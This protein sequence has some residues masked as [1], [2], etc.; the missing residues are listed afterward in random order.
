[1]FNGTFEKSCLIREIDDTFIPF[2]VFETIL[3]NPR[4]FMEFESI[5]SSRKNNMNI[6]IDSRLE[7]IILTA[8]LKYELELLI[9]DPY[10][11]TVHSIIEYFASSVY[12]EPTELSI[13][14]IKKYCIGKIIMT[15]AFGH[16]KIRWDKNKAISSIRENKLFNIKHDVVHMLLQMTPIEN[17]IKPA[18]AKI[19]N[20]YALFDDIMSGIDVKELTDINSSEF[21]S[22]LCILIDGK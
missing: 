17:F 4:S 15:Y 11:L 7:Y 8:F 19:N 6:I 1:M 9:Y 13:D 18:K 10:K 5:V 20:T 3:I 2:N 12:I 14:E 16:L 21:Y 22:I